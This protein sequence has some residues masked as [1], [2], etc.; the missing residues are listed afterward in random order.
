MMWLETVNCVGNYPD[1]VRNADEHEQREHQREELHAFRTGVASEHARHEFVAQLSNRLKAAGHQ[2]PSGRAANHQ[3]RDDRHRSEHVGRRIGERDFLPADVADGEDLVD[4]ELVDRIGGHASRSLGSRS[5]AGRTALLRRLTQ[6]SNAQLRF[7]CSLSDCF[8]ITPA[9]RI[10]LTTPAVKP[11]SKNTM[12]PQGEVDSKRSKPQPRAAPTRTPAT[13][14]EER[15][16]PT[17]MADALA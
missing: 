6:L 16:S 2:L 4:V 1:H 17:A 5:L 12:R 15:R 9:D 13:S 14:S 11:S 7:A 8:D 3:Q 10:T